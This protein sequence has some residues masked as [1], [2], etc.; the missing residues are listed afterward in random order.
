MLKGHITCQQDSQVARLLCN[1]CRD[2]A[3]QR[4]YV[5]LR[6]R[7]YVTR[8]RPR[9]SIGS[10]PGRGAVALRRQVHTR[11]GL[12]TCRH[13]TPAWARPR[14]SVPLSPET[15][16]WVV[17]IP[18]RGVWDPTRRSGLHSWGSWMLLWRSGLHVQGSDTFP[19]GSGPTVGILECIAFP[20][21][22]VTLEP[23]M[24]WSRVLFP[25]RLEIVAW[26]PRPHAVARGTPDPGYRQRPSF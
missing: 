4:S 21:R 10:L 20:G 2:S 23:S 1:K 3:A 25:T 16:L 5:R 24:W 13:R 17:W 7:A 8:G 26:A 18:R 9:G 12:D 6:S 15:Q 22:M 19:W 11:L 14:Y